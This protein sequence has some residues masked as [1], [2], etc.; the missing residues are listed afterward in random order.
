[1]TDLLK[2]PSIQQRHAPLI[3]SIHGHHKARR[4]AL[5]LVPTPPPKP[6]VLSAMPTPDE[7]GAKGWPNDDSVALQAWLLYGGMLSITKPYLYTQTLKTAASKTTHVWGF[8]VGGMYNPLPNV[9]H[10]LNPQ[11][12]FNGD[13]NRLDHD[14]VFHDVNFSSD[15]KAIV[16]TADYAAGQPFVFYGIDTLGFPGCT[17]TG[18]RMHVMMRANC[19]H[20]NMHG[21]RFIDFG[22]PGPYVGPVGGMMGGVAMF[23]L[24]PNFDVYGD[25][26]LTTTCRGLAVWCDGGGYGYDI[27]VIC[28]GAAEAAI[29]G[30]PPG[31]T[32]RA[33]RLTGIRRYDVSGHGIESQGHDWTLEI[34][35]IDDCDGANWYVTDPINVSASGGILSRANQIYD[36]TTGSIICRTFSPDP[37]KATNG[38]TISGVQ[39]SA[40]DGKGAHAFAWVNYSSNPAS[41]MR[42]VSVQCC[43]TGDPAQWKTGAMQSPAGVWGKGCSA[44]GNPGIKDLPIIG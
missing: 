14:L 29:V 42:N 19:K 35:V 28:E 8:G 38:L 24:L 17:F 33:K 39:P 30:F 3:A 36:G 12:V 5:A 1:M 26:Y 15:P 32:I 41:L 4:M 43:P 40:P 44:T 16:N 11:F 37:T 31:S 22:Q 23:D 10:M 27:G 25:M 9:V 13:E 34:G 6:L 21:A 2:P 20:V 7:F 18:Y